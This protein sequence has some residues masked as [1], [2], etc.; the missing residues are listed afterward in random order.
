LEL[1]WFCPDFLERSLPFFDILSLL[2]Y[3]LFVFTG[4][5]NTDLKGFV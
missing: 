4:L 2:A 1:K 3:D 5:Y